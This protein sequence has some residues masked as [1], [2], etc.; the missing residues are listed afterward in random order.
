MFLPIS[1][2]P[3]PPPPPPSVLL[4][5]HCSQSH[6]LDKHS[7]PQDL[8]GLLSSPNSGGV[9]AHSSDDIPGSW[10]GLTLLPWSCG[11]V[12]LPCH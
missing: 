5:R 9:W 6:S 10:L 3:Q 12:V 1:D 2:R 11:T 8:E 4:G 7:T